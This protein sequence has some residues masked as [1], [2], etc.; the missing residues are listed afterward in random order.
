MFVVVVKKKK[1]LLSFMPKQP[2]LKFLGGY[3]VT[4]SI[5]ISYAPMIDI[6]LKFLFLQLFF[7][8]ILISGE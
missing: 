1:I 6:L 8:Y 5:F 4:F 3:V 2:K 7:V